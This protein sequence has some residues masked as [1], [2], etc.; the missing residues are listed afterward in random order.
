MAPKRP[1][2]KVESATSWGRD[3]RMA[4]SLRLSWVLSYERCRKVFADSDS[5][6]LNW[7]S[8]LTIEMPRSLTINLKP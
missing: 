7:L 5:I 4:L 1:V 8:S 3:W 6:E 2:K